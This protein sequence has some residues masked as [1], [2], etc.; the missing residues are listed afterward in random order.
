MRNAR[1]V[2]PFVMLLLVAGFAGAAEG[3]TAVGPGISTPTYDN[4]VERAQGPFDRLVIR[5]VMMIDGTGAP[6]RG[7]YD[8]VVE[9]DRITGI[10]SVG[11]QGL[12]ADPPGRPAPGDMEIDGTGMTVTPGFVNAH[13]HMG[14]HFVP[15]YNMAYIYKLWL[16]HGVTTVRIAGAMRGLDWTVEQSRNAVSGEIEAPDIQP[17]ARLFEAMLPNGGG[18][19]QVGPWVR[20]VKAAG[21]VGLKLFYGSAEV[22]RAAIEEANRLGMGT[23]MHHAQIFTPQATVL[24]T[25]RWGLGSQEHFWY[26]LPEALF[27]DR[28]I[29]DYP[30]DHNYDDEQDRFQG[31]ARIWSQAAPPYSDRWNEVMDE[32]VELDFTITPTFAV[33]SGTLDVMAARRAEWHDEYTMP[34]QWEFFRPGRS[35]HGS[36]WFDWTSRDEA[37]AEEDY[38]LGMKFVEEFKNRGGRVVAGEDAGYALCLY[39]FCYVRELELLQEAGFSALEVIRAATKDGAELLQIGDESGTIAIG[40]R[41]DL[42]LVDGNPLHNL[43]IY[44]GTK[45]IRLNDATG[46]VERYGGVR[47]TIKAG[48][49]YDAQALLEDVRMM[50]REAKE[51]EGIPPGPMPWVTGERPAD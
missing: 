6:M 31:A 20:G 42:V 1:L 44:R 49:V 18:P 36:F 12:P 43:Q 5:N 39:G 47:W 25:A 16:A 41:A 29:Q 10:Q 35:V 40:K 26:G 45:A 19:G 37:A 13:A 34:W 4:P 33:K 38:E 48:V 7:P 51:R 46:E 9:G 3:D 11:L 30:A 15:T 21:A 8:I 24:D 32:L 2:C 23:M 17:Y 28:R 27:T 14:P 50:V 22:V